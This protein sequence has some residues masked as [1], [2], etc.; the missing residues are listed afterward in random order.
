MI[1]HHY[2]TQGHF[3]VS[4]L[5]QHFHPFKFLLLLGV[6]YVLPFVVASHLH[7]AAVLAKAHSELTFLNDFRFVHHIINRFKP[8]EV[9]SR[10]FLAQPQYP[11][12]LLTIEILGL[13]MDA[14]E[15][16]L[17]LIFANSEVFSK[18]ELV[19]DDVA[20]VARTLGILLVKAAISAIL[21]LTINLFTVINIEG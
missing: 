19:L 15:G 6:A 5:I 18:V 17:E 13:G 14:A 3:K 4:I 11:I 1:V 8:I 7:V 10:R 16:V 2:A 21:A 9:L 12:G 20:F